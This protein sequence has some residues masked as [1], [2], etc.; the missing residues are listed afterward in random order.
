M[1]WSSRSVLTLNIAVSVSLLLS[2]TQP[3]P[4]VFAHQLVKRGGLAYH[5]ESTQPFTD[6]SLAHHYNGVMHW[7]IEYK[8]GLLN[9][10]YEV[11]HDN[12]Q[13][14]IIAESE[15]GYFIG[16]YKAFYP[17][18][19]LKTISYYQDGLLHGQQTE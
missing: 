19:Q 17:S 13:Q 10:V 2:C 4:E 3:P 1:K 18:G 11:F 6:F 14:K 7:R 16:E 12:G 15:L 8:D 5:S 9:G